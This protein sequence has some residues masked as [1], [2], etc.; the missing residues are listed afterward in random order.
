MAG[1]V[2]RR[3]KAISELRSGQYRNVPQKHI[4]KTEM[5]KSSRSFLSQCSEAATE[6]QPGGVR[7]RIFSK[8]PEAKT[9]VCIPA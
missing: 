4:A 2:R 8:G 3:N 7:S 1:H 6:I 9:Q 5:V